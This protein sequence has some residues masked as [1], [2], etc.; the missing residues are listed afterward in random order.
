MTVD[1]V[2]QALEQ[3][4]KLERAKIFAYDIA[5]DFEKKLMSGK[6]IRYVNGGESHEKKDNPMLNAYDRLFELKEEAKEKEQQYLAVYKLAQDIINLAPKIEQQ[7][8]LKRCYLM[9]KR[10]EEIA[11][12]MHYSKDHVNHLK[13]WGLQACAKAMTK[14]MT[15]KNNE[16][17]K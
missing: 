11:E 2:K 3:V 14:N 10:P 6:T 16:K 1:E 4:L 5:D 7:E 13:G 12:H 15:R 8:V 17:Q 9:G